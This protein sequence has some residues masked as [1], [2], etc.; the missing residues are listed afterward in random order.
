MGRIKTRV[1]KRVTQKMMEKHADSFSD[2]F[3]KNKLAVRNFLDIKSH[4]L[5]NIVAGYVTK[6]A[7]LRK[8]EK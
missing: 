3:A 6:L 8:S 1:I 2:D 7:K 4:K 5:E